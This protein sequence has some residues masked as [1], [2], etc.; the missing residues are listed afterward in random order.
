MDIR[1]AGWDQRRVVMTGPKTPKGVDE[2]FFAR[3][4]CGEVG[5]PVCPESRRR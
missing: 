1:Q 2:E 3:V 5:S 4:H